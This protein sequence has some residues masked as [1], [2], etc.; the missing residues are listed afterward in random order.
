VISRQDLI[1]EWIHSR[2]EDSE[3]VEVYRRPEFAFPPARGRE[4]FE[5]RAD[6]SW[7]ERR[8]GPTDVPESSPA[9]GWELAGST[10]RLA[11]PDSGESAARD[12]TV[13]VAEPDRLLLRP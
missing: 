5:L 10:L 6:G 11:A 2:E 1:G 12:L 7:I 3:G 13:V 8:P 9:G 4:G